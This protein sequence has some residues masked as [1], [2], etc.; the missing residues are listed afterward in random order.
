MQLNK[1]QNRLWRTMIDVIKDFRKGKI[2]FSDAVSKLEGALD[3]GE[4]KNEILIRQWYDYW[5]PLEILNATKG[6]TTTVEDADKYLLAMEL[7]L[8]NQT[9]FCNQ[10]DEE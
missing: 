2:K 8:N 1:H 4:F 7:F 9:G 5:T 10:V 6:D 3:A